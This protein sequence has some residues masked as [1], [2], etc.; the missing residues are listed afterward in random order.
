[1]AR[2]PVTP[3]IVYPTGAYEAVRR[4]PADGACGVHAY[5]CVHPGEDLRAKKG[6][7][8]A[9]PHDGWVLVSM[10]TDSAPFSGYGP[11][12]VLLAHDDRPTSLGVVSLGQPSRAF[13]YSLLAHLDPSRLV[14]KQPIPA[15]A[16]DTGNYNAVDDGT[17]VATLALTDKL[18]RPDG[19]D[20]RDNTERGASGLSFVREG[21]VLGYIGAAGHVHWEIRKQPF[22]TH[23][24]GATMDPTLWLAHYV[25]A[26]TPWG[27]ITLPVDEYKAKLG[28]GGGKGAALAL[29]LFL[30]ALAEGKRRR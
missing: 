28:R 30:L 2:P 11:S 3:V 23:G 6:K 21:E 5:P 1:M 26:S 17:G 4:S 13:R 25:D 7:P 8:V 9:A 24:I 19:G 27:E 14:Y 15:G 16:L 20:V 22:G 12:V 29:V 18:I 10:S